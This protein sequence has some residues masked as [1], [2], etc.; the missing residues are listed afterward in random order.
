MSERGFTLVELLLA[1]AV[2][3]AVSGAVASMAVPA[4]HAFERTLGAADISGGTRA[5]LD[6]LATDL[7]EAGSSG[8][9]GPQSA[10]LAD[11]AAVVVPL[12]D[13][14][15]GTIASPA[16]AIRVMRVARR[17]A[18]GILSQP[19]APGETTVQ[20]GTTSQ[21]TDIGPACGFEPGMTAVV[22]DH[23]RASIVVVGSVAAGAVVLIEALPTAFDR[24]ATLAAVVITTYGVREGLDGT[25]RLVRLTS[26]GAEQ[27][28]LHDVVDFE[29]LVKGSALGPRPAPYGETSDQAWPDYGPTPPRDFADDPRDVWPAGENCTIARRGDGVAI[30]RLGSLGDGLEPVLLSTSILTDGPWCAGPH[31]ASV[32][33]ADLLR[34]REIEVRLRVEAPSPALR[35]QAGPLF[36]RPG[37]QTHPA[38][39]VPD[40]ELRITVGLRNLP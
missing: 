24:G 10:G 7:R 26:G 39:W 29:L 16:R 18:Q 20:L 27:P 28:M 40:V 37:T 30:P 1:C 21:C 31:G 22:F 15:S 23:A 38:R 36:R 3:L 14:D 9:V 8:G 11:V 5:A 34:L 6:V 32:F 13:L 33:D 25:G 19:V 2:L 17:A 35:G 12:A 4:R